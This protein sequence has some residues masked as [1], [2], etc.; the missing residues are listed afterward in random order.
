MEGKDMF[1]FQTE[2]WQRSFWLFGGVGEGD[3]NKPKKEPPPLGPAQAL[4][5]QEGK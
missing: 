2:K 4:T 5:S 3:K 1:F